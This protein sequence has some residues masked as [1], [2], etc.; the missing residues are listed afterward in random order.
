VLTFFAQDHTSSEMV[1]ANADLTKAEQAREI[2]AFADYWQ[3]VAGEDLGLLVF[4]SKLTP[5][6]LYLRFEP[7]S[8]GELHEPPFTTDVVLADGGVYEA[9]HAIRINSLIDN[10]VRNLRERQVIGG[11]RDWVLTLARVGMVIPDDQRALL[12]RRA[13]SFRDDSTCM[14]TMG[15]SSR[16]FGRASRLARLGAT[17]R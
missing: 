3:N 1:Y 7:D 6:K 15:P 10:Q 14:E 5:H 8:K 9:R 17:G 13:C 11:F 2:L 12:A 4:D 16:I